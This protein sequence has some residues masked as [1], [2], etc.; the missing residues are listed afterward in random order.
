M[1]QELYKKYRPRKL[2]QI[3]GNKATVKTLANMLKRGTLPHTLLIH[4]VSGTGKT[5]IAR[6]LRRE[7][8]CSEM[9]FKEYNC[10][11]ERGIDTVRDIGNKLSLSPSSGK[12][13][14]YQLDECQ[15]L[16]KDAQN[17]M[18]KML[19]DTPAHVYFILTTTDPQDLIKA[20]RT[21]CC[22]LPVKALNEADCKMLL[23][24][25]CK[26]EKIELADDHA[27]DITDASE[28]SARR[29]L[30]ILDKI[31]NLPEEDRTEAIKQESADSV[32]VKELC[33][34]IL[35]N[36]RGWGHISN[37]LK[38]LTEDPESIRYAVLGYASGA[39]LRGDNEHAYNIITWF[40]DPFYT[41]K[42]PGLVAAC[43]AVWKGL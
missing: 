36:E 23:R 7:L 32:E 25:V 26:R 18:L 37:I 2:T 10:S 29:L 28:G 13:R 43:Y 14:I 15:K 20:I 1:T 42:K 6:I 41:S 3:L 40:G 11:K 22:D 12:T 5:S 4:G 31:R 17:A 8:E 38:G 35:K 19:E 16:T 33:Q 34:A 9:D 24:I 21:R 27:E 39:L 30:V